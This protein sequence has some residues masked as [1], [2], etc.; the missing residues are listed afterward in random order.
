MTKDEFQNLKHRLNNV[1]DTR[2]YADRSDGTLFR[3]NEMILY[4]FSKQKLLGRKV[5]HFHLMIPWYSI[6]SKIIWSACIYI[7]IY[8]LTID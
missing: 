8:K 3:S 2:M 6:S 5:K 4:I 7:Y 1:N